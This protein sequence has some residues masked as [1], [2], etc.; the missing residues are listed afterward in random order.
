M[1]CGLLDYL[2]A[3]ISVRALWL[4]I[5]VFQLLEVE[6]WRSESMVVESSIVYLTLKCSKHQNLYALDVS[7]H[8]GIR[9]RRQG[10][11][12]LEIKGI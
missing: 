11:G 10:V 9:E 1:T 7:I 3:R 6:I 12:R 5:T 8:F 2:S 4:S